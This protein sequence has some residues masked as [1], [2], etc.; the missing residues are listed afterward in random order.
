M[1][2]FEHT[3]FAL[4]FALIAALLA[5]DGLPTPWQAGWIVAAMVGARSAAMTFN[6]IVDRGFDQ[7][8]PRTE[9]RAL[10]AGDLST[11]FAAGFTIVSAALFVVAAWMLNPLCFYLSFPMLGILLGYSY[12]KRFT[13][14]SHVV[15]GF[16]IGMAPLGAW[17]GIRGEFALT[18][19]LLSAAVMLWIGGFDIIYACQDVSFDRRVRLFSMPARWGLAAALRVSTVFHAG[20]VFFLIAVAR[21]GGLG[22]VAYVGIAVVAG[23]LYWEHRI[24]APD[25]LSRVDMAFFNLNGYVSVLLLASVAA[26][27]LL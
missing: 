11:R 20:T 8:N 7:T 3:V 19:V 15:L 1:I 5:A 25:D 14:L 12:T 17:L 18:P 21:N 27:V 22:V 13:S 16:A 2:K 9:R 6:R 24:V 26:D 10:P 4:P 23:I